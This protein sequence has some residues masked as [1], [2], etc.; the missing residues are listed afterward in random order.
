MET[1]KNSGQL[2]KIYEITLVDDYPLVY[3]QKYQ[4][5][6]EKSIDNRGREN[7]QIAAG[8]AR[9]IKGIYTSKLQKPEAWKKYI[10]NILSGNKKL[11]ALQEEFAKV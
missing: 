6:V 4:E 7:Y 9:S 1:I 3:L 11:K 10:A 8:Y 2:L 5:I